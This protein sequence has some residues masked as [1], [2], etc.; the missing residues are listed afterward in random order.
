MRRRELIVERLTRN[1]GEVAGLG[2]M[3]FNPSNGT[4]NVSLP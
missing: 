1:D 3:D 2:A 4:E